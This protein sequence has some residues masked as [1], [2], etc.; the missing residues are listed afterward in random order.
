MWDSLDKILLGIAA[1]VGAVSAWRIS[2]R[3]QDSDDEAAREVRVKEQIED[4]R[5]TYEDRITEYKD[6]IR[7]LEQDRDELH[8]EVARL[9]N[10]LGECL[11]RHS[12]DRRQ[13]QR[14]D[15]A[16]KRHDQS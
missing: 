1:L 4:M 11:G 7:S 12:I 5:R 3:K 6:R 10:E 9:N 13:N 15:F 16:G 14:K 8:D 2:S